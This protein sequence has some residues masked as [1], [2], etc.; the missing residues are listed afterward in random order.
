MKIR[1]S[2]CRCPSSKVGNTAEIFFCPII[3]L[4]KSKRYTC[5]RRLKIWQISL[6][7]KDNFPHIP[8]LYT[9]LQHI[10]EKN[11]PISYIFNVIYATNWANSE[12][13]FVLFQ[14]INLQIISFL[15]YFLLLIKQIRRGMKKGCCYFIGFY[16]TK[17]KT[18]KIPICH[19]PW[20]IS[21]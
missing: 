12:N 9:I 20:I 6:Y 10:I 21:P 11:S 4:Q 14:N 1:L 15:A 13:F 3:S 5:S 19:F 8:G 17:I 7:I 18:G 2:I 16:L